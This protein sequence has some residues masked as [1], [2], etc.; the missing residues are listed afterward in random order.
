M[1][2]YIS[3]Y[4][5]TEQGLHNV[6]D[7][8]KRTQAAK[9]AAKAA[10]VRVIGVWW[11]LGEYDLVAIAEAPDDETGT[12]FLLAQAMLGNVKSATLRAFSEEEM[13]RIVAGLP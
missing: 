7:T 2:A 6:K 5:F 10:G 3:L 9:E 13:T 12:R 8:V 11:T 1:P 4:K